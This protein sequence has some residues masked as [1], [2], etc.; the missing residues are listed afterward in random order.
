MRKVAIAVLTF[1]A[2]LLLTGSGNIPSIYYRSQAEADA[3]LAR[4]DLDNPS[5]QLWT[6][7]QK[8]CSRTGPK[9]QVHCT[10]DKRHAARPSTPFC[11]VRLVQVPGEPFSVPP[12]R[13]ETLTESKA[14]GAS[15]RRFCTKLWN[16]EARLV[17]FE[18][19]IADEHKA[20]PLCITYRVP[21]PFDGRNWQSQSTPRC[22][23]WHKEGG[24]LYRCSE[25]VEDG[26]CNKLTNGVP[27]LRSESNGIYTG[28]SLSSEL[29]TIWGPY[30]VAK[31]N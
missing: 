3:D 17:P 7:W 31:V 14:S 6:N 16:G 26:Y 22:K 29:H 28:R 18:R 30:C 8:M 25:S 21:R 27:E 19:E 12:A 4:Y 13:P 24:G 1:A 9:G 5:C 20:V 11:A 2:F 15:R 23:Q 10:D